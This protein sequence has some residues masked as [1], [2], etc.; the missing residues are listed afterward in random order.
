[1]LLGLELIQRLNPAKVGT[2]LFQQDVQ[3]YATLHALSAKKKDIVLTLITKT[4]ISVLVSLRIHILNFMRQQ[5]SVLRF[6]RRTVLMEK[7]ALLFKLLKKFFG[8]RNHAINPHIERAFLWCPLKIKQYEDKHCQP[9]LEPT[10]KPA[11]TKIVCTC[12]GLTNHTCY[13]KVEAESIRRELLEENQSLGCIF[14]GFLADLDNLMHIDDFSP[15]ME[16]FQRSANIIKER[17]C[18]TEI[19]SFIVCRNLLKFM[20]PEPKP[21]KVYEVRIVKKEK[22]SARETHVPAWKLKK[23]EEE[24]EWEEERIADYNEMC[25]LTRGCPEMAGA[26]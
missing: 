23:W 18:F 13:N 4:L 15:E 22:K 5:L 6:V 25:E 26:L 20:T 16:D 17:I 7:I 3:E 8:D 9:T 24:Q 11:E 21:E 19:K 2:C 1:M 10:P 14:M 12:C